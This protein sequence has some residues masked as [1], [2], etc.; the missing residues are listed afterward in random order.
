[1]PASA[2]DQLTI[3]LHWQRPG[4]TL[5]FTAQ[6]PG[7]GVTALF[8]PSGCGKTTCLRAIAG[9]E[10][11]QGQVVING[12]TWQDDSRRQWLPTH[13]RALGYV[14]QEASL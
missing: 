1:M 7:R 6:L 14:F 11:A 9:L 4:F 8:G 10:R 3:D 12:Q 13:R 5:A 2:P